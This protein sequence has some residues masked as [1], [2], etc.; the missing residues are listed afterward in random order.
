MLRYGA[1]HRAS[2][3]DQARNSAAEFPPDGHRRKL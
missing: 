2:A 1:K 3:C